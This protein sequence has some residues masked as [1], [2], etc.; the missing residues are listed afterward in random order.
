[1]MRDLWPAFAVA[2]CIETISSH[3]VPAAGA[4][5]V[6]LPYGG[7][8]K[9]FV[10]GMAWNRASQADAESGAMNTCRGIDLE[11]NKVP[12]RAS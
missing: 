8:N 6:G 1:M 9:G 4:L 2:L 12:A 11:N 10:Y 7:A 5:A 3:P